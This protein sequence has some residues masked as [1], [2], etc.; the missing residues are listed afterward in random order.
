M[1]NIVENVTG[2]KLSKDEKRSFGKLFCY[3]DFVNKIKILNLVLSMTLIQSFLMEKILKKEFG[4]KIHP[5]LTICFVPLSNNSWLSTAFM[6]FIRFIP[7]NLLLVVL[8]G[9]QAWPARTRPK[10]WTAEL[11]GQNI[12]G[13]PNV[14][15]ALKRTATLAKN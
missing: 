5:V 10:I 2:K 9:G 3:L 1:E 12:D 6:Y 13:R 8:G 11:A 15:Q 4:W 7:M 14:R